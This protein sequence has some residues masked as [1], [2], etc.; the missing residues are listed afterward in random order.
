LHKKEL[1][2]LN[3]A[4]KV[5]YRNASVQNVCSYRAWSGCRAFAGTRQW[6]RLSQT[7]MASRVQICCVFI[8]ESIGE[9]CCS[10]RNMAWHNFRS[11][12]CAHAQFVLL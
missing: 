2:L 5:F 4:K 1:Y 11:T 6:A 9:G 8:P 10:W 3:E 7:S 12:N